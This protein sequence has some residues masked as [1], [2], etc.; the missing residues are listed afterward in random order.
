MKNE[1]NCQKNKENRRLSSQNKMKKYITV[2]RTKSKAKNLFFEKQKNKENKEN[3][4]T[5]NI[6]EI[7]DTFSKNRK[8]F[9]N[10]NINSNNSKKEKA[11]NLNNNKFHYKKNYIF[12]YPNE[13]ENHNHNF[14]KYSKEKKIFFPITHKLK[15]I[16]GEKE[17]LG[18]R[19]TNS[20]FSPKSKNRHEISQ[21][22]NI[23]YKSHKKINIFNN[24]IQKTKTYNSNDLKKSKHKINNKK[25]VKN[26]NLNINGNNNNTHSIHRITKDTIFEKSNLNPNIFKTICSNRNCL[27]NIPKKLNIN[28]RNKNNK[29]TNAKA[30]ENESSSTIIIKRNNSSL[31]TFG[32]TNNDSLSEYNRNNENFLLI[33]KKENECLKNEL[34]KTKEKVDLLENKIDNLIYEKNV[35]KK[36]INNMTKKEYDNMRISQKEISLKSSKSQAHL[37]YN[38]N[39]KIINNNLDRKKN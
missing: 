26:F 33:L 36:Q 7:K 27:D 16:Y 31:L 29:N 22:I 28:R 37:K 6:N 38:N 30:C 14:N 35:D 12:I 5:L 34:K 24:K 18:I 13:S 21:T 19:Q 32:N 25:K 2:H 4:N 15:D 39:K 20:Y 17:Y 9:L 8:T 11:I 10:I 3:I 1:I 23:N